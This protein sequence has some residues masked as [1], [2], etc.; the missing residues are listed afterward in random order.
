MERK[1]VVFIDRDGTINKEAGYINHPDNFEIYP[2]VAQAVRLLNKYDILAVVVT[3]Q[4]GIARGYF[5]IENMFRLH[6]KMVNEL[7]KNGARLDGIY[8]CP[9]HP[10]SKI[11][12]YAKDCD[13][14]KPKPGMIKQAVKDLAIDEKKMYVVGDKVSDIELG[15]NTGCKTLFVLTGYGKGELAKFEGK[16]K[17]PDFICENLLEAVVEIIKDL[18][19]V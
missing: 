6:D 9:H 19:C 3:N 5:P 13:C 15:W 12:E 16:G 2:F 10:S 4:A 7:E 11:P 18:G 1:P 17:K 14:R 8:Y